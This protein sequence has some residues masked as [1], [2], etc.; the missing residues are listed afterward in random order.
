M[1]KH[2]QCK[3]SKA[4]HTE[5]LR[6]KRE[7]ARLIRGLEEISELRRKY[8]KHGDFDKTEK[9][10]QAEILKAEGALKSF[11]SRMEQKYPEGVKAA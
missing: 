8:G 2:A 1:T 5:W 11:E 3:L 6:L 7:V 4:E 10:S 9:H